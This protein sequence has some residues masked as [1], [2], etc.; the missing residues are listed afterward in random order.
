MKK[1]LILLLFCTRLQAQD[2]PDSAIVHASE[3]M[4]AGDSC[5]ARLTEKI[6]QV[7]ALKEANSDLKVKLSQAKTLDKIRADFENG[8][9]KKQ[10]ETEKQVEKQRKK[11]IRWRNFGIGA[12]VKDLAIVVVLVFN[13]LNL[14]K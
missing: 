5:C 14:I 13:P 11:K 7:D 2:I 10:A 8:M 1:T 12:V 4:S 3:R 6:I 9:L